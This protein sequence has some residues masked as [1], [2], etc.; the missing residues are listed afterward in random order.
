MCGE[1]YRTPIMPLDG[2]RPIDLTRK[3]FEQ[4]WPADGQSLQ[5]GPETI[6]TEEFEDFGSMLV[7][8]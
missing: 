3:L 7:F 2:A 6:P 4:D 8:D 1:K 5:A